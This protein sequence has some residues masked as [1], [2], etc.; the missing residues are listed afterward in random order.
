MAT[1]DKSRHL[2]KRDVIFLQSGAMVVVKWTKTLQDRCKVASVSLPNLGA[3]HLCPIT[4]WVHLL[5]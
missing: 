3:S 4:A 5:L 1:F 2:C